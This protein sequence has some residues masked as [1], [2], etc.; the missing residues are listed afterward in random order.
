MNI[1]TLLISGILAT[2]ILSCGTPFAGTGQQ[3]EAR[4]IGIAMTSSGNAAANQILTVAEDSYIAEA[5]IIRARAVAEMRTITTDESGR[6]A[7]TVTP[8][9]TITISG[10]INNDFIYVKSVGPAQGDLDLG[11][12]GYEP[13]I[14]ITVYPWWNKN[15]VDDQFSIKGT[16]IGYEIPD[17][18]IVKIWVPNE[19]IE[20][21]HYDESGT[22]S[23][24]FTPE[25]GSSEGSIGDPTNWDTT[26][27][28]SVDTIVDFPDS[29]MVN[30]IVELK[31]PVKFADGTFFGTINWGD[32][33][34]EEKTDSMRAVHS[35]SLEGTYFVVL[36]IFKIEQDG[37]AVNN[38][39][40]IKKLA[41]IISKSPQLDSLVA[42]PDSL[43]MN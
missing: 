17:T 8:G 42:G 10:R 18:A 41:I 34:P 2:F 11:S 35:Y 19:Q 14:E 13:G 28:D 20:L 29:S 1:Q 25:Q 24:P 39:V 3:G 4:V 22:I 32:N 21:I 26:K 27:V 40:Q 9:Q 5:G 36:Q 15:G 12:V 30:E 43:M 33:S 16:I 7:I 23:Y 31:L 6:F 37:A 38:P